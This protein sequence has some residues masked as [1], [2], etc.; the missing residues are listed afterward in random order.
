MTERLHTSTFLSLDACFDADTRSGGLSSDRQT[1]ADRMI[2]WPFGPPDVPEQQPGYHGDG[3]GPQLRS[4][5]RGECSA[6]NQDKGE[7]QQRADRN[8]GKNDGKTDRKCS[9][10][11]NKRENLRKAFNACEV[12]YL[13]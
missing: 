13:C 12:N 5:R 2:R 3:G 1:D 9:T 4:K 6:P 10:I 11:Q 8:P 7:R